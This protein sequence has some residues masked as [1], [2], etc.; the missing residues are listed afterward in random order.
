MEEGR[1]FDN[2]MSQPETKKMISKEEQNALEESF[3]GESICEVL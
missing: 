2:T 3:I 1:V